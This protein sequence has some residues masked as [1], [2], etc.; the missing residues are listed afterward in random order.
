M[1]TLALLHVLSAS[2]SV[3]CP[4]GYACDCCVVTVTS[5]V[6][7]IVRVVVI[8]NVVVIGVAMGNVI[9]LACAVHV[10]LSCCHG[11]FA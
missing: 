3:K 5:F 7:V 11:H 10:C 6:V 1:D 8:V 9:A 4:C 2:R